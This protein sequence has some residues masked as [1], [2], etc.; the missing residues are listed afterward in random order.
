MLPQTK[1]PISGNWIKAVFS[2]AWSAFGKTGAAWHGICSTT[3]AVMEF[4][5]LADSGSKGPKKRGRN[6]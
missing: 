4:E 6:R 1:G 3:A 5:F 2:K